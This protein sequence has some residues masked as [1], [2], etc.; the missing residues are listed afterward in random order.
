MTHIQ[1]FFIVVIKIHTHNIPKDD[2]KIRAFRN[3]LM[4][5]ALYELYLKEG[6][7]RGL[8]RKK[9]GRIC[10]VLNPTNILGWLKAIKNQQFHST[11]KIT[12][13]HMGDMIYKI[14]KILLQ[15][16]AM[17]LCQHGSWRIFKSYV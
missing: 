2:D 16:Y 10:L 4:L 5:L 7:I 15:A 13:K 6:I 17:I 11:D 3:T 9:K 1:P 12:P 14:Q 8:R